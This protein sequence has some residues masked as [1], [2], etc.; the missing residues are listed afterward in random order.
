[1]TGSRLACHLA[2]SPTSKF[3]YDLSL[4]YAS[5][6]IRPPN[7]QDYFIT[8]DPT[9][10]WRIGETL[11]TLSGPMSA[12]DALG[13]MPTPDLIVPHMFCLS[14]MTTFRSL[15]ANII[16]LPVVGSLADVTIVAAD[17]GWTRQVLEVEGV[18]IPRGELIGERAQPTLPLPVVIKPCRED[19]S[20]GVSLVTDP[21]VISDAIQNARQYDPRVLCEE[22]IPGR[23]VRCAVIEKYGALLTPELIEYDVNKERPIRTLADKLDTDDRGNPT[24]QNT[25]RI[26]A[27][28]C[29]ANLDP[30][31]K[32]AVQNLAVAA[33]RALGARDYSL[34]DIRIHEETNQPYIIEAGL[35]WSFSNKS[36]ITR[37]LTA[38]G[39]DVADEIS[40]LWNWAIN[41]QD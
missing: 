28:V 24:D 29:P 33:H 39:Y 1:M 40:T 2:G 17:K 15:F 34:F 20:L 7:W 5:D 14:G 22:F 21:N 26:D 19:N 25:Q 12:A 16:Q 6:V 27:S 4:I 3:Y 31:L 36:M 11:E 18:A 8:V 23:E 37:M 41:R 32:D 9:G 38:S 30:G 35:F 13:S 10:H